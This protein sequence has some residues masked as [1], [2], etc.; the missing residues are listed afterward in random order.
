MQIE[1]R[2][3]GDVTILDVKGKMT[4]GEGDEILK[5]KINSLVAP[6]PQEARPEPGRRSVHRQRR[7]R[8]DRPDLHHRQPP[9]R[10]PEAPQPDQA[11]H[12]SAV[13]HQ[14]ADRLRDLRQRSRRRPELR[15]VRERLTAVTALS[16]AR[17][18]SLDGGAAR[19]EL[20]ASRAVDQ[21]PAASSPGCSSAAACSTRTPSLAAAAAFA[22]FCA[23]SGAGLPRST[24]SRTAKP[25]GV[26][27]SSRRARSRPV[28]CR[29]TR[30]R[31]RRPRSLA[32]RRHSLALR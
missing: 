7:P 5:D 32:A 14:A 13:D 11:D 17:R 26:I 10:Q 24:T 25:I 30:R 23:L 21:E 4:L 20:A 1:E 3:A 19:L 18:P 28:S 29:P 8:R 9:G 31:R 6:G 16:T 27:R 12:R 15:F 22:I 2:A